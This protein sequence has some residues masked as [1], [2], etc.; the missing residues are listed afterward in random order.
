MNR[1]RPLARRAMPFHSKGGKPPWPWFPRVIGGSPPRGPK[2]QEKA[3]LQRKTRSVNSCFERFFGVRLI[4][5][6]K[7]DAPFLGQMEK[8]DRDSIKPVERAPYWPSVDQHQQRPSICLRRG[9][10]A[11]KEHGHHRKTPILDEKTRS[12]RDYNGIPPTSCSLPHAVLNAPPA[13]GVQNR[14]LP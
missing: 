6:Q 9:P 4:L 1:K 5:N 14:R 11:R 12:K 10:L 2:R 7:Q 8:R 3:P 13:K